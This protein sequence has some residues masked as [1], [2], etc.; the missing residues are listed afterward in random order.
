MKG[1]RK[2]LYP[3]PSHAVPF[4]FKHAR[5]V[6]VRPLRS[7][8][9]IASTRASLRYSSS[10]APFTLTEGLDFPH[11]SFRAP[12]D[13]QMLCA[14][15]EVIIFQQRIIQNLEAPPHHL[16]PPATQEGNQVSD[17]ICQC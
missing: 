15:E 1:K 17:M 14:L 12:G 10:R 16:L 8:V 9:P 5:H 7:R 13:I 6:H 11:I 4:A 3:S 2:G